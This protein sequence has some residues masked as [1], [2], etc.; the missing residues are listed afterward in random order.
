L[1]SGDQVSDSEQIREVAE[2]A[3]TAPSELNDAVD[4]FDSSLGDPNNAFR[5]A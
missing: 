4:G 1:L 2:P 3:S 5:P